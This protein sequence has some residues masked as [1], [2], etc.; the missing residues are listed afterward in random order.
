[1]VAYLVIGYV[2]LDILD[3]AIVAYRHIVQRH[4]P[5]PGMLLNPSGQRKLFLKHAQADIA[6]KA[7]MVYIF[8]GKSVRHF[9]SLPIVGQAMLPLQASDFFLSQVAIIH[10]YEIK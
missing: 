5:Q 3:A 10:D 9:Y 2:V 7:R 8:G 4:V 6:R 1:M